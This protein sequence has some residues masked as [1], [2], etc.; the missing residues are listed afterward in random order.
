MRK[1]R[2]GRFC[3]S[4]PGE[5]LKSLANAGVVDG[6]ASGVLL[7]DGASVVM[8]GRAGPKPGKYVLSSSKSSPNSSTTRG[9]EERPS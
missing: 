9:V 2:L 5:R 3:R 6:D 4:D 8:T 1:R 7:A